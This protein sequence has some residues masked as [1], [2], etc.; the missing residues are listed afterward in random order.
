MSAVL[1]APITNGFT[2]TKQ[3]IDLQRRRQVR[4]YV[5]LTG[6]DVGEGQYRSNKVPTYNNIWNG[7]S[8]FRKDAELRRFPWL[9]SS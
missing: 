9:K 4:L 6:S 8:S 5:R 7:N 1:M 2:K 3:K